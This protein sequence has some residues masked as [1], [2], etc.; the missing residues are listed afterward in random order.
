MGRFML[1][2]AVIQRTSLMMVGWV[3]VP[4]ECSR[5]TCAARPLDGITTAS[6]STKEY[7]VTLYSLVLE[8][9][10]ASKGFCKLTSYF[11][12]FCDPS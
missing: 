7:R 9:A 4:H 5:S 1:S 3:A 8:S 10:D 6:T 11:A 2:S 12:C